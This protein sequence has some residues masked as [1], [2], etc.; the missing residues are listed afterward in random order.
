MPLRDFT[1]LA[2]WF[3][4]VGTVVLQGWGEPLLHKD[5]FEIIR[6]AKAV[7]RPPAA[8]FVTSGKGLDEACCREL[9]RSGLDFIGISFAGATA[10]V[11][12]RIRVNSRFD[13][14]VAGVKALEAVKRD[15]RSERPKTHLV[16]LM[17][18]ENMRDLALLPAL[19]RETGVQQIV[20]INLIHAATAWQ[21]EQRVFRCEGMPE[22]EELLSGTVTR[23]REIGVE[24]R[25]PM[26]TACEAAVCEE[27]PLR[28]L[29]VSVHGE[30]SPCVFLHPPTQGT[31]PRIFCGKRS[32]LTP[33]SFGNLFRQP[34]EEI[35][36]SD[37]YREFRGPLEKRRSIAEGPWFALA[38]GDHSPGRDQRVPEAP[39]PCR[40]CHKLLGL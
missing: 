29:Y 13:E 18:K 5:L 14:L 8:G 27:D 31:F 25:R 28:N 7:R 36:N 11:H 4:R 24:I 15:L 22:F 9:V 34:I 20:L 40:T 3:S 2:A 33:V 38:G 35:W 12:E 10:A 17:L 16:Y 37:A 6:T 19:A 23:A 32:D 26:L 1:R 30:V 39:E 21:E